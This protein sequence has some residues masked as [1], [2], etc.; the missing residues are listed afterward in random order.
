MTSFRRAMVLGTAM[1]S[2]GAARGE[3]LRVIKTSITLDKGVVI[4]QPMVIAADGVTIDGNGATLE[5]SGK[6]GDLKTFTGTGIFAEG[7]SRVAIRHLK[8]RG[9]ESGL[10]ATDGRQWTIEDCDFSDNY[11][12]PSYG[13]GDYK[14]VGGIILTRM[15]QCTIRGNKA[16]RVWNG[17]DLWESNE[18]IIEGNDFSHC[19]NVCLKLWQS[20]RH[21]VRGNNLS[22]G[23]RISP[24]EVHARDSTSVLIETGS[25]DNRFSGNDITH[26]G[27]GVFIRVLNGWCSTGNVF[28]ENDCSYA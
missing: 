6:T 18:H 13:W 21:Q 28:I 27:D 20:C 2:A 11:H 19:S 15:D 16:N 8:V 3:D 9:Y 12:D 10:V 1:L 25:D 24:G 17:L 5:G 7:R 22:Y 23:L 26:G 14:R 4:T